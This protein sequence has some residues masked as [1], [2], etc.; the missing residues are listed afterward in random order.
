MNKEYLNM[1]EN[2][3]KSRPDNTEDFGM[4]D[5][6]VIT[7][8]ITK[9]ENILYSGTVD[10]NAE[11]CYQKELM[12]LY[13][14]LDTLNEVSENIRNGGERVVQTEVVDVDKESLSPLDSL[15]IVRAQDNHYKGLSTHEKMNEIITSIERGGK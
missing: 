14:V 15:M 4:T 8:T 5:R 7:D 13:S 9:I 11:V 12:R 10:K 3:R 6:K 1:I 2:V